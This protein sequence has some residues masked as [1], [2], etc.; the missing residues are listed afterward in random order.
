MAWK[1]EFGEI[2][3]SG[4]YK[5]LPQ[6]FIS[7]EESVLYKILLSLTSSND[8]V[9]L[10]QEL[11]KDEKNI[12]N[13]VGQILEYASEYFGVERLPLEST[14]NLVYRASTYWKNFEGGGNKDSIKRVIYSFIGE[15]AFGYE[16]WKETQRIKILEPRLSG[17]ISYWNDTTSGSTSYWGS[18]YTGETYGYWSSFEED[19]YGAEIIIQL[20]SGTSTDADKER[21]YYQY[22][23]TDEKKILLKQVID[24]IRPLGIRYKITIEPLSL[25]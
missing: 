22:W 21:I 11:R 10:R 5:Y 24:E 1:K 25:G 18:I 3:S 8:R 19:V 20:V 2:V 23:N 9:E 14:E 7:N 15:E 12:V 16:G 13:A 6:A 4:P 17:S